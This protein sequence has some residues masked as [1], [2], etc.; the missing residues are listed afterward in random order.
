MS[1][2][3][4]LKA[5]AESLMKQAEEVRKQEIAH[6]VAEIRQKMTEYGLTVE[7]I[8]GRKISAGKGGV[9]TAGADKVIRYRGPNGEAWSGGAGRRPQWVKDVAAAGGD[10]EQ[11]RIAQS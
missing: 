9:K 6:V 1:S 11:Y 3:A 8:A 4:E 2:Y 5:Q 10:I 7:D